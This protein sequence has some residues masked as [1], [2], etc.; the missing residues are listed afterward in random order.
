MMIAKQIDARS[1]SAGS[2]RATARNFELQTLNLVSKG[3]EG[4]VR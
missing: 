3:K 4:Q 1:A 2:W